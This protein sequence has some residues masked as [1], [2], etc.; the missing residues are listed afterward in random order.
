MRVVFERSLRG[1]LGEQERSIS[2]DDDDCDDDDEEE[3][4]E[5]EEGLINVS[6]TLHRLLLLFLCFSTRWS[7]L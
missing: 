5:E 4:G 7:W 3:E 1:K 2:H 6:F